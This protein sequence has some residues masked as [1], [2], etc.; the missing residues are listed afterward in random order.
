MLV[1]PVSVI[2]LSVVPLSVTVSVPGD[3]VSE[4][5]SAVTVTVSVILGLGL[6]AVVIVILSK[7]VNERDSD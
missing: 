5:G 4:G 6:T 1:R 2:V 7:L 3:L